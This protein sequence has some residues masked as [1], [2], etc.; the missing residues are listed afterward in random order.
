MSKLKALYNN[1]IFQFV[2]ELVIR[3]GVTHFLDKT[4]WGFI[5]GANANRSLNSPRIVNVIAVGPKVDSEIKPGVRALIEPL[6]WTQGIS[7][8]GQT[9]WK[10]N[11]D[12]V[13]AIDES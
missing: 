6:K 10:T 9:Y 13:L 7:F 4:D 3:N 5:I 2:D 8:E 1:I 11:N 12:H